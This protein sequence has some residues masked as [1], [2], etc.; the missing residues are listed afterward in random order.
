MMMNV[1][2]KWLAVL[3][4][5]CSMASGALAAET[6]SKKSASSSKPIVAVFRLRAPIV[7]QPVNEVLIF[8][9]EHQPTSLK[10]LVRRMNKARD[11]QAVKAVV[12]LLENAEIG[13]AQAEE[14]RQAMIEISKSGKS[15]YAHADSMSMHGYVLLSAATH[16]S[17]APTGDVWLT[18]LYAESMYLRG[19]L[20]KLGVKP[21][22]LTCGEYKSA[23]ET[24]MREGPSP[25]AEEMENWLLD[26]IYSTQ[27][28]LIAASRGV[29]E[30]KARQWIDGGPY[31]AG[32]ARDLGIIDAV[33]QRQDVQTRLKR[34]FGDD[35]KFEHNYGESS[36]QKVDFSSPFAA[37]EVFGELLGGGKKKLH[38][39]SVAIVYVDGPI[40]L[41]AAEQSPFRRREHGRQQR[42]APRAG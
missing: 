30:A 42:L 5:A 23:A 3:A 7:E 1:L 38:K 31:T 36:R 32:K 20:N 18:G 8:G 33:E 26:G 29:D 6:S 19:L 27:V 17:V 11:D 12:V 9:G 40:M 10:D 15:V 37:F 35:I 24:F 13:T 34:R 28:K 22:F 2:C 4:L 21:D 25:K 16:L 14:I 39:T 41:G